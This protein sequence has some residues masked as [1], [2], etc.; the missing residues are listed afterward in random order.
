[1]LVSVDEQGEDENQGGERRHQNNS[2]A[3]GQT[4][5]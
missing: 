5:D 1:M 2:R 4:Q 3:A